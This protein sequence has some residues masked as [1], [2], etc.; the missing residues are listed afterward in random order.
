MRTRGWQ[1]DLPQDEDEA[2]AR[3]L[4]AATRI[5][6]RV[7]LAKTRL[8]DVAI[9]AGVTRQTVYRYFSSVDEM[10]TA[11]ATA[12]AADFLDRMAQ[13]LDHVRTADEAAVETILYCLRSMPDEPALGLML[14]AGATEFFTREATSASAVTLGAEMLR[15]LP[16]DWATEGYDD[17]ALEGLAELVMRIWLSFQQYPNHPP[18][19]DEELRTYLRTWLGHNH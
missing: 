9:E 6:E 17:E 16:V 4:A 14:R 19:S 12:G 10:L 7:G 18:R 8:A 1:G 15:R 13:A 2:R 3:I 5:V 11:V